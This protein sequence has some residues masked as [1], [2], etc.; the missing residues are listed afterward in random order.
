MSESFQ[1]NQHI[2]K[3]KFLEKLT[4]QLIT[5]E[6]ERLLQSPRLSRKLKL[7]IAD[8]LGKLMTDITK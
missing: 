8:I 3:S 6:L 2:K 1:D 4:F 5:P 7:S